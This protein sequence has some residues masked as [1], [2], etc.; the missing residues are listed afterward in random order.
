M[1]IIDVLAVLPYYVELGMASLDT[2]DTR[3]ISGPRQRVLSLRDNNVT[4]RSV[5][6][7]T[8]DQ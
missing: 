1:N 2:Q 4:F 5:A 8:E 6:V 3:D 7:D